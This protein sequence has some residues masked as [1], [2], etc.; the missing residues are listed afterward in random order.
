MIDEE[1]KKENVNALVLSMLSLPA[2]QFL[3]AHSPTS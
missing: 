3:T 2:D 1:V